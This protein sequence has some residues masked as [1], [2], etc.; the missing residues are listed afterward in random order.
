[1]FLRWTVSSEYRFRRWKWK[2]VQFTGDKRGKLVL[3]PFFSY[4][5]KLKLQYFGHLMWRA[6]SLEKTPMLVKMEGKRRRGWL[7][8]R[9][10]DSITNSMNMNLSKLGEIVK[11]RETWHAAIHGL[12]KSQT[13]LSHWTITYNPKTTFCPFPLQDCSKQ[14]KRQMKL[15]QRKPK[16]DRLRHGHWS[17]EK[18]TQPYLSNKIKR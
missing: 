6:D 16:Q 11:D 9:W 7:R 8:I 17:W 14:I 12:P 10:L 2:Q 1:M 4:N 13:W 3:F 5:P 15:K 18:I